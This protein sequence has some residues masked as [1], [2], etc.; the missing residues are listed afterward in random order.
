[1]MRLWEQKVNKLKNKNNYS[2]EFRQMIAIIDFEC[3]KITN[4]FKHPWTHKNTILFNKL[5]MKKNSD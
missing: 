2:Y 3:D 1:M 4:N 5:K